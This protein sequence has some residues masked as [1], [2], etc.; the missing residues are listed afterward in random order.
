MTENLIDTQ[1]NWPRTQSSFKQGT[2]DST[3]CHCVAST[4]RR[5]S[6][7][8]FFQCAQKIFSVTRDRMTFEKKVN[9][10]IHKFMEDVVTQSL[11]LT[12]EEKFNV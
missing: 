2:S 10:H 12:D 11:S 1:H 4:T 3:L 5:G 9:E 7:V 6:T 8:K